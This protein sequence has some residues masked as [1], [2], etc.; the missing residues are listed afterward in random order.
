MGGPDDPAALRAEL[1]GALRHGDLSEAQALAERILAADPHDAQTWFNLGFLLR[2]KRQFE[3]AL[4]AYARAIASGLADPASA[5]I[6]R[7]AIFNEHLFAFDA[8]LAELQQALTADPGNQT[9]LLNLGQLH[10]D[11]GDRQAAAEIYR[12]AISVDPACGRAS[13]RLGQLE[14]IAGHPDAALQE[15]RTGLARATPRSDSQAEVLMAIGQV[16]ERAQDPVRAFAAY[17]QANATMRSLTPPQQRYDRRATELLVDRLIAAHPV[18]SA[19][20]AAPEEAAGP[21]FIVGMLRSG[22]TLAERILAAH[23]RIL[24]AGELE[25]IPAIAASLPDYP[26]AVAH[27]D[28]AQRAELAARYWADSRIDPTAG[29][30]LVDKRPDNFLHLGL[31]KTLFPGARIIATRRDPADVMLSIYGNLFGPA[32]PY[33]HDLGDI[34][35]WQAQHD[36][37]MAHWQQCWPDDI[38]TLDYERLIAD[39]AATTARL[40]DHCG[41]DWDDACSTL[42]DGPRSVRTLSQWQVREAINARSLGRAQP[43]ARWLQR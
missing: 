31:I 18:S 35:H 27:L 2:A 21:I 43:F 34:R 12:T 14:L 11:M 13:A 1:A 22:S 9:A 5:H 30:M 15:L 32:V 26:A 7:A 38:F 8:A 10:E 24:A 20:S 25:A 39:P 29:R 23:P 4:D 16:Y 17:D 40:L 33:A 19:R 28:A 36:R 42:Q 6:N 37:L 3:P 41:L